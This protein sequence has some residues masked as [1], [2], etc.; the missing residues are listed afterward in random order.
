MFIL[1]SPAKTL[2][3]PPAATG[4]P[5]TLPAFLEDTHALVDTARELSTSQLKDLMGISDKLA[6]LNHDRFQAFS[7]RFGEDNARQAALSFNGHVYQG[8]DAA[9]LTAEDLA[10][11]QDHV[12][13]LS[14]LYGLLR[15]MDLMQAYRLEMGTALPTARGRD[16]YGFWGD[17]IAA[18]INRRADGRPI[19]NLA[20]NEYFKAAKTSAL[21]TPVI[22]PIFRDVKDGKARTLA[23]FA[24]KARGAMTRWVVQ[25]RV[26]DVERLRDCEVDGYRFDADASTDAKWTFSR[27]Q[28]PKKTA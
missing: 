22:T 7:S 6:T 20:S 4:L 17:R 8:L 24:K 5:Q 13:I 16:L 27:P 23:F 19:V 3:D 15:P 12:G 26:T 10:F 25:N 9:T 11:A 21:A 28:P 2:I 1:L 18:E 14:G